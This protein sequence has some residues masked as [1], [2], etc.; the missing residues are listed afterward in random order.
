MEAQL[1]RGSLE[2]CVLASLLK[3]DSY[4][5]KIIQ[6]LQDVIEISE[7]TLYPILRRLEASDCLKS[8]NVEHNGRLRKFYSITEKG[9]DRINEYLLDFKELLNVFNYIAKEVKNDA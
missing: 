5:Y 8:Y 2:V 6:S 9:K 3:E 7:S 4:G 1:K